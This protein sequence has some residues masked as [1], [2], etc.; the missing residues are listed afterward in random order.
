MGQSP[1]TVSSL[2]TGTSAAMGFPRTVVALLVLARIEASEYWRSDGRCGVS[3]F[4]QEFPSEQWDLGGCDPTAWGNEEG[5]CCSR[6]GWCG[7]T[8]LHC[9]CNECVDYRGKEL[10]PWT[11]QSGVGQTHTFGGGG[12]GSY[13]RSRNPHAHRG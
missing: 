3:E 11:F 4:G 2:Q 7:N 8:D 10:G 6:F 5:P 13:R 12:S 1:G 9:R